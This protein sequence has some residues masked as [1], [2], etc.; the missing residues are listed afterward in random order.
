MKIS[1]QLR[2]ILAHFTF[3]AGIV[4]LGACSASAKDIRFAKQV[5]LN[6]L[7]FM[8]V[9]HQGLFEKHAGALGASDIKAAWLNFAGGGG[10]VDALLSGS[11]DFVSTGLSN[12]CIVWAR[13]NGNVRGVAGVAGVPLRL[14]TKNPKVKS[15]AD[16]SATD[17]IAVPTIRV[18]NQAITLAMELERLYGEGAGNRLDAQTVQLSK[19]DSVQAILNPRHEVTSFYASPPFNIIALKGE[20]VRA[21]FDSSSLFKVPPTTNVL[22]TSKTFYDA[23][24]VAI[25]AIIAALDEAN[26]IIEADKRKAAEFYLKVTGD[27]LSVDE[28]LAVLDDRGTVFSTTPQGVEAFAAFMNRTKLIA[29]KPDTW[30]DVFFPEISSRPGS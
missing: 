9:E 7:P 16:F 3:C 28:L 13:T 21:I 14:L 17:R 19:P 24:P 20:G 23:N 8:I 11:V 4:A 12:L 27:R 29:R 6:M 2:K 22:F 5:Q 25:K 10:G 26:E 15:I 18:S 1:N 30:R